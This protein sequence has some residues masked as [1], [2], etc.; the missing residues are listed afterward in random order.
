MQSD[1]IDAHAREHDL[2]SRREERKPTYL[3]FSLARKT[4]D[5][6]FFLSSFRQQSVNVCGHMCIEDNLGTGC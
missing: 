3:F 4:E 6:I 2:K 5:V 1:L